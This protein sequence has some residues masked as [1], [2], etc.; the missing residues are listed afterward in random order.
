MP[1]TVNAP[2][3][4]ASDP[5]SKKM[6]LSVS[7]CEVKSLGAEDAV[8]GPPSFLSWSFEGMVKVSNGTLYAG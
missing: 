5:G 4:C 3:T 2:R 8:L 6:S 7:P 1:R